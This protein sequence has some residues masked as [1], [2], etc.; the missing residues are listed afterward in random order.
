MIIA[1]G[2]ALASCV[3]VTDPSKVRK[4]QVC[5]STHR[6]VIALYRRPTRDEISTTPDATIWNLR[7]SDGWI[8]FRFNNDDVVVDYAVNPGRGQ[9]LGDR[10]LAPQPTPAPVELPS[11]ADGPQLGD[12]A[13]SA[14]R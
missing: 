4:I 12:G 9:L 5:K 8:A 10:C 2:L 13:R 3:P 1:L 7:G 6:D 14:G 11:G